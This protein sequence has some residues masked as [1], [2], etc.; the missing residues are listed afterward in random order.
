MTSTKHEQLARISSVPPIETGDRAYLLLWFALARRPWKTLVLVPSCPDGSAD[1]AARMLAEV[2]EKVSGLPVRAITMTSLDYGT[3]SA[4]A[5][6]Q[7]RIRRR[8]TEMEQAPPAIDVT[9][10]EVRAGSPDWA[11]GRGPGEPTPGVAEAPRS[12]AQFVIA[13][14]SLISEPLGLSATQAA[15]AVVL[16]VELGRTRMADLHRIVDQVGRERVAG[17]ILLK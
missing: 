9:A 1:E 7:E 10:I 8:T 12:A 15:D 2:G 11:W 14:P 4:L 3:A 16:L 17:C 13:I 6:L 5:D